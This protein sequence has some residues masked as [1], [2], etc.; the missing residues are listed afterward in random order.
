MRLT[1]LIYIFFFL[2]FFCK[3]TYAAITVE[4]FLGGELGTWKSQEAFPLDDY[5]VEG[6]QRGIS[7]GLYYG[8]RVYIG[9]LKALFVGAGYYQTKNQWNVSDD[10]E[11]SNDNT[12]KDVTASRKSLNL[13]FGLQKP[14]SAGPLYKLWFGFGPL[15]TLAL[16]E[17]HQPLKA[18]VTY[19]GTSL[20]GGYSMPLKGWFYVNLEFS[21]ISM[22]KRTQGGSEFE[23]PSS[24]NFQT[25]TSYTFNTIMASIS[26]PFT[27]FKQKIGW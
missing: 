6:T 20:S 13:F 14:G 5:D 1:N 21:V 11:T 24:S 2:H 15:E 7:Y 19:S 26:M 4:P 25:Y 8:S 12:W 22:N 23:I 9:I 17:A 18:A 10:P 16:S 3:S 27:F